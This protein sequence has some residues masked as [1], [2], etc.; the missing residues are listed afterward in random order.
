[1]LTP[2]MLCRKWKCIYSRPWTALN[3][4]PR[5]GRFRSY[6][7]AAVVH[8]MGRRADKQARQP[9]ALDPQAFDYLGSQEEASADV[10]WEREWQL[11][12]LRWAMRSIAG[13]FEP[14]TLQA[15]E[16]HVLAGKPV[17]ETA[18]KLGLS[19]SSVYQ[20]KSRIL[21][22]LKERLAAADPDGNL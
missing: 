8:A 15:F 11:H 22:C 3:T 16:M 13:E 1:M 9:A 18:D 20:A 2:K 14:I 7:R 12:R 4:T 10:R 6:L 17:A 19:K 5:K 21:K